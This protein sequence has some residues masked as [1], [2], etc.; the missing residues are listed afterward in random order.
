MTIHLVY[1]KDL[2]IHLVMACLLDDR[3]EQTREM[4]VTELRI[5]RGWKLEGVFFLVWVFLQDD[6]CL[7]M[8]CML[9]KCLSE[10]RVWESWSKALS[11]CCCSELVAASGINWFCQNN[12][13]FKRLAFGQHTKI[14]CSNSYSYSEA[15]S[16]KLHQLFYNLN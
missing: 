6:L 12:T 8:C 10:I 13:I 14:Q 16:W 11:M 4:L 2:L 15:C 1:L 3:K 9:Q 5:Y 7:A